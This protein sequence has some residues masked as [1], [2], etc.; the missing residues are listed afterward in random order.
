MIDF[1]DGDLIK[2]QSHF[3]TYVAGYGWFG[4]L[5]LLEPGQGYMFKLAS[6]NT[7]TFTIAHRKLAAENPPARENHVA[8]V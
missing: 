2:S 7:L 3:S 5:S 8:S 4:T 1:T 6:S